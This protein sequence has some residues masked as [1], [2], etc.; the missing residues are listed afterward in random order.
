MESLAS[1]EKVTSD[2]K[3]AHKLPNRPRSSNLWWTS[4]KSNSGAEVRSSLLGKLIAYV[5]YP[6]HRGVGVEFI[7]QTSTK[8]NVHKEN[9]VMLKAEPKRLRSADPY[10]LC[11][12][13]PTNRQF[14]TLSATIRSRHSDLAHVGRYCTSWPEVFWRLTNL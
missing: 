5:D 14:I 6:T 7:A 11:L 3:C 13:R 1:T 9:S 4:P 12:R 8:K 10:C 2:G